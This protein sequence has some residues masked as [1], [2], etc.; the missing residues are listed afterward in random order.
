MDLLL[1]LNDQQLVVVDEMLARA[2]TPDS[3]GELVAAAITH[4]A[5][6]APDPS[7]AGPRPPGRPATPH[8]PAARL[9]A[10]VPACTGLG[11]ALRAGET[12][13]VEQVV[14]GQCADVN[15]F[16]LDGSGRRLDA[17]RSRAAVGLR[18]TTGAVLVSTPPEIE[19]L[20]IA[21]DTAGPHDLGYPACSAAEFAAVTAQ[22]DHSNCVDLQRETQ[23]HWGLDAALQHDPLNLWLPTGVL[24]DGRLCWWPCACR[25]GDHVDLLART[26]VL[27]VVN[28]CASDLFGSSA[29]ELGPV[30]VIVAGEGAAPAEPSGP[31]PVWRWR[32]LAVR[33]IPVSVPAEHAG[34]LGEV[35]AL[36]WLGDT[37]AAAA[38]AMLMRYWEDAVLGLGDVAR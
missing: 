2:D 30:R 35:R 4:D 29:W 15:V 1:R 19:L 8:D 5:A 34:H 14:D 25:A 22:A 31:E 20:E 38:R 23:R 3:L 28:P 6:R 13:R 37:D 24:P 18:P 32:D 27:V 11:V 17:A 33:E 10:V 9:D 12:L 7:R 36:G 26:D 16:A 21:A